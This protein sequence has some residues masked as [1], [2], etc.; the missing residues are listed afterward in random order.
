MHGTLA[1]LRHERFAQA[2]AQGKPA[3]KAY[4]LAGYKANHPTGLTHG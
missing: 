2:L 1:N 4:V 3:T